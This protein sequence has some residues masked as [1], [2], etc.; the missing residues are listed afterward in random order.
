M[1]YGCGGGGGGGIHSENA[2]VGGTAAMNAYNFKDEAA[3]TKAYLQ[4]GSAGSSEEKGGAGGTWDTSHRFYPN[5]ELQSAANATAETDAVL[6]ISATVTNFRAVTGNP[7][8]K[9]GEPGKSDG[10]VIDANKYYT[11]NSELSKPV[12]GE[13]G[14]W[15]L[16]L[17][18]YRLKAG[19]DAGNIITS[20]LTNITTGG[21]GSFH[22]TGTY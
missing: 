4:D 19:G 11:L 5:I 8:G 2:G 1:W 15:E 13:D 20:T 22:G 3:A 12:L 6:A 7:G 14:T 16:I 18:N 17:D 9:I 21:S 10:T